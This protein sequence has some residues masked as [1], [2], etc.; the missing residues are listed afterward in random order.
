MKKAK[1]F[2]NPKTKWMTTTT[3]ADR[4]QE[5]RANGFKLVTELE[6]DIIYLLDKIETVT[7]KKSLA[8]IEKVGKAFDLL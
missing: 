7:G 5:F 8:Y 1:I 2:Y 3:R 4:A 6:A